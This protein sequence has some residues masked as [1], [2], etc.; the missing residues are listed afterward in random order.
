ML[1]VNRNRTVL[2]GWRTAN[3]KLFTVQIPNKRTSANNHRIRLIKRI[4][5]KY[6]IILKN[7]KMHKKAMIVPSK[8]AIVSPKVR[9]H[10][11]NVTNKR[12]MKMMV[13]FKLVHQGRNKIFYSKKKKIAQMLN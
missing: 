4:H 3:V 5:L 8:M 2:M 9:N 11:R 6:Q 13:A 12:V 7:A 10:Q 1:K